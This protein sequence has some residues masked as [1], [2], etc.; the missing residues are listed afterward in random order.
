MAEIIDDPSELAPRLLRVTPSASVVF[1]F[2]LPF[3]SLSSCARDT[4]TDATGFEIVAGSRLIKEQV[5][6]PRSFAAGLACPPGSWRRLR[7]TPQFRGS[8]VWSSAWSG[9][10]RPLLI[11]IVS[12]V[13][14][15]GPSRGS[16]TSR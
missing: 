2:L 11:L 6:Q 16:T 14:G 10:G 3:F 8:R 7:P 15:C 9:F 4:E 5:E 1:C 13:H 12:Y